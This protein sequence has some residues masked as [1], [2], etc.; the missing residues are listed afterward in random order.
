MDLQLANK[1]AVVTG[2]SRGTGLAIARALLAE[3]V[4]VVGCARTITPALKD[5]GAVPVV[6]DVTTPDGPPNLIERAVDTLGG[7][8]FVINNVG[9]KD[10]YNAGGFLALDD[11]EWQHTLN[12]NLFSTVR[13]TRAAL[14]HLIERRGA[15]VN[16]SSTAAR[17]PAATTV[18]Y[19]AAKAALNALTKALDEEFGPQGVRALT[20]SPGPINI[21]RWTDPDGPGAILATVLDV[22]QE[23]VVH[24]LPARFRLTT[25]HIAE[26]A[27]IGAL[28]AFLLSEHAASM[29]G[30]DIR[31]DDG[32]VKTV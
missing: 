25:G 23:E 10:T 8:D 5:S 6:C 12:F 13:V 26:P 17:V 32:L 30:T 7:L 11:A 3:G 22:P 24:R 14:P 1:T 27:H 28:V 19:G 18:D 9:G 20:V 16:I 29:A 4:R 2:A 15:I 21:E 31:I